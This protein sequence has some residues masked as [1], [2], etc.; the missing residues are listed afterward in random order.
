[1]AEVNKINC[2]ATNLNTGESNC[3][4]DFYFEGAIEVPKDKE[5]TEAELK[6][7][8]ATLTAMVS[9]NNKALR[10]YPFP[11]FVGGTKEAGDAVRETLPNGA[12]IVTWEN[13]YLMKAEH[14]SGMRAHQ[15]WRSRNRQDIAVLIFGGG[16]VYGATIGGKYKGF[17]ATNFFAE[18]LTPGVFATRP[19]YMIG[20][21]IQAKYINDQSWIIKDEFGVS[22]LTGLYDVEL[23]Q[24][25]TMSATGLVVAEVLRKADG[26]D[27]GAL[28]A[29]ELA[30]LTFTATNEETGAGITVTGSATVVSGKLNI[31]LDNTDPDYPIVGK[32]LIIKAPNVTSLTSA[33][34]LK[35][36]FTDLVVTRTV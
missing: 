28:Y 34:I 20:F 10:A 1:M 13:D 7:L 16:Y 35:S 27:Y 23:K 15:A 4:F 19:Q 32:N 9:N 3:K 14:L 36:E 11:K 5:F 31:D 26:T 8:G 17:P 12:S 24:V 21:N 6:A 18:A 22:D 25:G 30:T 29:T 33:G 2:S